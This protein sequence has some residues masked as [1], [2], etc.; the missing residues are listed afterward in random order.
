MSLGFQSRD[1]KVEGTV[2][3]ELSRKQNARCKLP[4][5]ES[6]S[7]T[8]RVS[9]SDAHNISEGYS[10][11]VLLRKSDCEGELGRKGL[12]WATAVVSLCFLLGIVSDECS[13]TTECATIRMRL[14]P[15]AP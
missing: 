6:F 13:L 14:T 1:P 10:E 11:A 7:T 5:M 12:G 2:H 15:R 3:D 8:V 9:E 4:W